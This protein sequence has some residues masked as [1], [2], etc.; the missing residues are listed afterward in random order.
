MPYFGLCSAVCNYFVPIFCLVILLVFYCYFVLSGWFGFIEPSSHS[1]TVPIS[2]D[3]SCVR[4]SWNYNKSNQ[5]KMRSFMYMYCH[6]THLS[7][8]LKYFRNP[9]LISWLHS[10]SFLVHSANLG[11]CVYLQFLISKIE[12][13]LCDCTCLPNDMYQAANRN[14]LR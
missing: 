6:E 7:V 11:N 12:E 13:W 9:F 3:Y 10:V 5:I 14:F 4:I 8:E 2:M 1:L